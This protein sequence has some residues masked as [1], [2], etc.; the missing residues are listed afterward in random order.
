VEGEGE[1]PAPPLAVVPEPILLVEG[2]LKEQ[3][4]VVSIKAGRV[5]ALP[6]LTHNIPSRDFG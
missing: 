2:V 6:P 4:G 5:E 3:D 1:V